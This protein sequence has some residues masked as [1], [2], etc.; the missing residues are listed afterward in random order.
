MILCSQSKYIINRRILQHFFEKNNSLPDNKCRRGNRCRNREII[1]GS[2][3]SDR[4][5]SDGSD[6]AGSGGSAARSDSGSGSDYSDWTLSCSS[7][8]ALLRFSAVVTAVILCALVQKLF[9]LLLAILCIYQKTLV[10]N[11]G[12]INKVYPGNHLRKY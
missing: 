8:G 10:Q 5:D 11:S 4:S 7:C 2:G 9:R 1:S 12:F 6:P 3:G